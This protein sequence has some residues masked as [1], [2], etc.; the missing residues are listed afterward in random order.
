MKSVRFKKLDAFATQTSAGNPAGMVTLESFAEITSGEMQ[1][2]ARELRGF[3]NEVGFACRTASDCL[4]LRYYSAE[5]EVLFCGHATIAILYDLLTS[6]SDLGN[7]PLIHI[8]TAA[9]SLVVEN[10]VKEEQAVFISSPAPVFSDMNIVTADIALA[11]RIEPSDISP[12]RPSARINAGLETLLVP[13]TTLAGILAVWPEEQQL[14]QFC[15]GHSI[16]IVTLFTDDTA[17]A[18]TSWRSRVFAPRFGYLEDPAT[19]SGNAALGHY[20]LH[21]GFWDGRTLSIE[22][23]SDRDRANIVKLMTRQEKDRP[24]RVLFGGAAVRR[25]EGWYFL[26]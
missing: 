3:V 1:Q 7:L 26:R 11:L 15:D 25:I 23:N 2:I 5:K 20:L 18:D 17:R 21:N 16:D 24:V 10:R 22:Q 14:K 12:D 4:T 9:G 8:D 19:G 13:I 6:D